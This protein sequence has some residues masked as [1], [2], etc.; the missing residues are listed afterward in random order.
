MAAE[1]RKHAVGCLALLIVAGG[2]YYLASD[3]RGRDRRDRMAAI[4]EECIQAGRAAFRARN[5]TAEMSR[6]EAADLVASCF[7]E[8]RRKSR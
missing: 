4:R 8:A 2:F 5:P 1:D 3:P 7:V 6:K